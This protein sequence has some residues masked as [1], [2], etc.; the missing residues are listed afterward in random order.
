[1]V[2]NTEGLLLPTY[3]EIVDMK[4]HF[5][6]LNTFIERKRKIYAQK[7]LEIDNSDLTDIE[8]AAQKQTYY[9]YFII[10]KRLLESK[11]Y[12]CSLVISGV[13]N[14]LIDVNNDTYKGKFDYFLLKDLL[15]NNDLDVNNEYTDGCVFV[16]I[17]IK[18]NERTL[19]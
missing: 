6:E 10:C 19:K 12:S 1:M 11:T 14:T 8:K 3:D 4:N 7:L 13:D 2:A 16:N 17:A 15:N 5:P 18:S 9:I